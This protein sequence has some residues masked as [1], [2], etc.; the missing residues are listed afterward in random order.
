MFLFATFG[1]GYRDDLINKDFKARPFYPTHD[2]QIKCVDVD[3]YQFQLE[4]LME[5]VDN[6][7]YKQYLEVGVRGQY[8]DKLVGIVK[9]RINKFIDICTKSYV[10]LSG[11]YRRENKCGKSIIL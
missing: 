10:S 5:Q 3:K 2:S 11:S 4:S 1:A 6:I 8:I 9:T 7:F